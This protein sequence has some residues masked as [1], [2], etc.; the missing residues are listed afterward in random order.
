[1]SDRTDIAMASLLRAAEALSVQPNEQERQ[2]LDAIQA[3]IAA[4][5][6]APPR[7]N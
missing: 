4:L 7:S 2:A 1:M 6:K 5:T 3:A